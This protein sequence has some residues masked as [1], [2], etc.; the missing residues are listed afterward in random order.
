MKKITIVIVAVL[1]STT[2]HAWQQVF[3]GGN[4]KIEVE[5][6]YQNNVPADTSVNL[7]GSSYN[8]E[9]MS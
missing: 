5:G 2:A 7:G 1:I 4:T 3:P 9:S 6:C 8:V